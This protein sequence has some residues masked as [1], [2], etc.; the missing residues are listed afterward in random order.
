MTKISFACAVALCA[1]MQT[2]GCGSSGSAGA[3]GGSGSE[4]MMDSSL[5]LDGSDSGGAGI[6]AGGAVSSGAGGDA[7]ACRLVGATCA[8]NGDCCTASCDLGAGIC[9]N[10]IGECR[11]PGSSC[12]IPQDCCTF[13]CSNG[14]CGAKLCTSDNQAC[15]TSAECCGGNC[16]KGTAAVS[17]VCVPLNGSCRTAGNECSAHSDCCSR[18]CRNGICAGAVSFCSQNGDA[19]ASNFECCGGICTKAQGAIIGTCGQPSAPGATGCSVAGQLCGAGASSDGGVTANDAGLPACGGDCCSR[20]CAPYRTGVLVCQPPS[21][22][23]P[24]GE[25]C[26]SDADCCGYGGQQGVTGVGN[27]SKVNPTDPVGRCDNGNACRPAGAVCKLASNSCNA[28]NNCCSGNVNQNPF[29]CQQDILGIPRCTMFGQSCNDAGSKAGEA[30][31]TS[32]DCC[33]LPCVPNPSFSSDPDAGASPFICGGI[34][35]G[36]GGTC[37]TAADCCPGLPCVATPGSTRGTCGD[38][39]AGDA[40]VA[41]SSSSPSD[42]A[43][44]DQSVTDAAADA[45]TPCADYGQVCAVGSDCCNGVPCSGGRCVVI[46]R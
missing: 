12:A 7:G 11:A 22:C 14:T 26:R 8:A 37:S 35:I 32:A 3:G 44:L 29:V 20:A 10:A 16:G 9:T 39:P 31:A 17:G 42:A 6:G 25:V 15:S 21:G 5:G 24:T 33:G 23:R 28:E 27:C 4:A 13:A 1:G 30:C 18:V 43:D 41:D 36:A 45:S 40:G 19:C 46:I 34:C 38:R 2:I